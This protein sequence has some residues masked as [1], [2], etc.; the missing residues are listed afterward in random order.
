MR[1][2]R[3]Q[4]KQMNFLV[5]GLIVLLFTA[6]EIWTN[7]QKKTSFETIDEFIVQEKK[8]EEN[9]NI[10]TK[11]KER[12]NYGIM[13][14]M[15]D[16]RLN[17]EPFLID[18]VYMGKSLADMSKDSNVNGNELKTLKEG[19]I[20]SWMKNGKDLVNNEKNILNLKSIDCSISIYCHY[21]KSQRKELMWGL[22]KPEEKENLINSYIKI[23]QDIKM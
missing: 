22:Q 12:K 10:F 15:L 21:K 5:F 14:S 23:L 1:L 18:Y 16:G 19:Y 2:T 17:G 7:E 3:K 13:N 8:L 11:A 6:F 4:R 20:S 9:K